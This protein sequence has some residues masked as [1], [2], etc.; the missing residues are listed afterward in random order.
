MVMNNIKKVLRL[1]L[2]VRE[3]LQPWLSPGKTDSAESAQSDHVAHPST[4]EVSIIVEADVAGFIYMH[5]QETLQACLKI[6]VEVT[7]SI[8]FVIT[9]LSKATAHKKLPHCA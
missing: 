8:G 2:S 1:S 3:L 6:D 9:L 7:Q 5:A 4:E